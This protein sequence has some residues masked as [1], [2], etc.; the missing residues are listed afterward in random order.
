[1][2]M[3]LVMLALRIAC[4]TELGVHAIEMGDISGDWI[5]HG[6][7]RWSLHQQLVIVDSLSLPPCSS[8]PQPASV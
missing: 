3:G 5:A 6:T 7:A 4:T 2:A 1:M 8:T